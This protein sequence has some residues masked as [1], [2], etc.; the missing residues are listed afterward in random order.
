MSN[1]HKLCKVKLFQ[2]QPMSNEFWNIVSG[3]D[4]QL[5]QSKNNNPVCKKICCRLLNTTSHIILFWSY[6]AQWLR[7]VARAGL[8]KFHSNRVLKPFVTP[9]PF[10]VA[11]LR[12]T[13]PVTGH[14]C[15]DTH[16]FYIPAVS[17]FFCSWISSVLTELYILT[18]PSNFHC[19]GA[20]GVGPRPALANMCWPGT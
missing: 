10:N 19:F 8:H 11:L 14:Q 3:L 20:L 17:L 15:T 18:L 1:E 5:E 9:H 6:C 16:A 2:L 7:P 12:G 4:I 13:E